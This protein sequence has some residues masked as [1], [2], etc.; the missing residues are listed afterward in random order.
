MRL[1]DPERGIEGGIVSHSGHTFLLKMK[2]RG[3]EVGCAYH[4]LANLPEEDQMMIRDPKGMWNFF[5]RCQ[6][7]TE[8]LD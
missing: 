1:A 3:G 4:L 5:L 8:V 7:S 6:E 2:E